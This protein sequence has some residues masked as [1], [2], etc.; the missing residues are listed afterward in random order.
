MIL[1][2][3]VMMVWAILSFYLKFWKSSNGAGIESGAGNDSDSR[4][5]CVV[6]RRSPYLG[7]VHPKPAP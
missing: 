5:P 1:L 7:S 6:L 3:N 2:E 4:R